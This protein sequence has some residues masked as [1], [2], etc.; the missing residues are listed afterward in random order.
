MFHNLQFWLSFP[1]LYGC[2]SPIVPLIQWNLTKFDLVEGGRLIL[3]PYLL[4][5]KCFPR[6]PMKEVANIKE[7]AA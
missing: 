3:T 2:I 5:L 1:L 6:Y 7:V 4:I